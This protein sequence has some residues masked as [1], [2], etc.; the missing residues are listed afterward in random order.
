MQA[1]T[2]PNMPGYMTFLTQHPSDI[3][4]PFQELNCDTMYYLPWNFSFLITTTVQSMFIL[5]LREFSWFCNNMHAGTYL[6]NALSLQFLAK[7][8]Q[9]LITLHNIKFHENLFSSFQS[10]TYRWTN[11]AFW[12]VLVTYSPYEMQYLHY[13]CCIQMCVI[14]C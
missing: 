9:N 10:V 2:C 8:G 7:S 1:G 12:W 5:L 14:R 3:M 4:R 11:M 13:W 6:N